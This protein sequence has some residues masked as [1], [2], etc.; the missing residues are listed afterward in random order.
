MSACAA[1]IGAEL[2]A[3]V[4]GADLVVIPG[5]GHLSCAEA[6]GAFNARVREFLRSTDR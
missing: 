3:R 6:P 4:P 5:V 1:H 2:Q